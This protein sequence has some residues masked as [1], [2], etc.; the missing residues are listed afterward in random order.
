MPSVSKAQQGMMGADYQRA[1]E[2]KP[3]RTGMS[4][5]QLKDFASTSTKG[6][7]EKVS[8]AKGEKNQGT[9]QVAAKGKGKKNGK[10]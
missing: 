3:T 1:K 4:K 7:P 8:K 6:L 2:G 10:S 9:K 5:A